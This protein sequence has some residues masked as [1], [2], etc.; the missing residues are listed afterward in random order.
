[1]QFDHAAAAAGNSSRSKWRGIWLRN[2]IVVFSCVFLFSCGRK[3]AD[4]VVLTGGGETAAAVKQRVAAF[5][6]EHPGVRV[7]VVSSPGKDYYVKS[8]TMLAG[9]AHVDVLWMG[10]GFGIFAGRGALLDLD[11]LVKGDPEFDLSAYQPQVVDWYRLK[12]ALY[13]IPYGKEVLAIA[14][15]KDLFDAAGVPYPDPDWTLEEMLAKA[16]RLTRFDSGSRQMKCAGLGLPALDYRYYGLS[17]LDESHRRFALN[18]GA[19]REWLRRNVDLIN[20]RILQKGAELDSLDRLSNFLNGK[21]AMIEVATWDIPELRN[22]APFHWDVVA[23]PIGP[24]GTRFAW[25]SSSGFSITRNTRNPRLAWQM[26]KKL[27]DAD[28]QRGMMGKAVPS[29]KSLH[30]DYLK[31]YP[32][33]PEHLGEM[34]RL[35]ASMRPAPRIA[36]FQEVEAELVYWRDQ[37][38]LGKIPP[39]K[40]LKEAERHINRILDLQDGGSDQ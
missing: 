18:T 37:A 35:P 14:Y 39:E 22:R 20:E 12:G 19:G 38:L 5:E 28:F 17:L 3:E 4:L 29:M 21:V 11:P 10:Q 27:T 9:R 13:G 36:P 6:R 23:M 2:L 7:Q 15:N 16:R 8:L 25:A 24:A 30:E 40:A 34:I 32:A 31:A 33:P 26:L 1:M